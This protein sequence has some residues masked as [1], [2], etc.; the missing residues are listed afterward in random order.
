M[1]PQDWNEA[2]VA[3][4]E[5]ASDEVGAS[6][7][8]EEAGAEGAG[9]E[10]AAAEEAAAE[11]EARAGATAAEEAEAAKAEARAAE[12][13]AATAA[14]ARARAAAVA[15]GGWLW[16][17]DRN[18]TWRELDE[19]SDAVCRLHQA[20][21]A[22]ES[23]REAAANLVGLVVPSPSYSPCSSEDEAAQPGR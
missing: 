19:L 9:A 23:E 7:A 21:R 5:A 10:G 17:Q 20:D 6:A 3:A 8:A 12:T 22:A 16:W 14:M 11:T 13:R 2:R 1:T 15:V 4:E 18:G